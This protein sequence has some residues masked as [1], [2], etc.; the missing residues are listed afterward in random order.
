MIFLVIKVDNLIRRLLTQHIFC[1]LQSVKFCVNTHIILFID[2]D[3]TSGVDICKYRYKMISK[4]FLRRLCN[5]IRH[6]E[7]YTFSS[8]IEVCVYMCVHAHTYIFLSAICNVGILQR[9]D[10]IMNLK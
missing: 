6:S 2:I 9:K 10:K 7:V 8:V 1:F 4:R 3:F 5:L